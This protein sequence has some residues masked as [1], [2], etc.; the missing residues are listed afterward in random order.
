MRG[1]GRGRGPP[2]KPFVGR[3]RGASDEVA[4]GSVD[5][6]EVARQAE[7]FIGHKVPYREWSESDIATLRQMD[8]KRPADRELDR[9]GGAEAARR[10]GMNRLADRLAK[11]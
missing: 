10:F 5:T 7:L 3:G 6:E 1:G 4:L 8:V 9:E 2:L 11:A